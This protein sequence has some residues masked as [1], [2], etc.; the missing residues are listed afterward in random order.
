MKNRKEIILNMYFV[1]NLRPVDIAKKLDISKSAVTQ[2]LKK[3]KRYVQIKQ[4]RKSKNQKKHIEATKE[5]IK[6]KRKI[7]QFKNNA[8]DL[9]LRNMHNQ[10]SAELSQPRKMTNMAFRNWNKSAYSYNE[11]KR[12]FEFREELGRAA[13]VPKYIKVEVL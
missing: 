7:A 12:R 10:A 11:K 2:V 3:D 13:D 6:T 1:E 8:D 5:H 9:I 4:K